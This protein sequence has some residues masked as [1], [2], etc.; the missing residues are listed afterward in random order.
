VKQTLATLGITRRSY[1]RWLKEEAWAKQR[2][3]IAT[4]PVPPYEV[5][6]EEKHMVIAYAHE[7]P[8]LRH[9]ELAWKMVDEDVAYVS[10]LTLYQIRT[11]PGLCDLR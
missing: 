6:S 7:H 5:L 4:P 8:E 10:P 9:R 2:P 3:L 1:Y 11:E